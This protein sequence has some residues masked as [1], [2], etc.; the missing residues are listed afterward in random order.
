MKAGSF[1][2]EGS[3][4]FFALHAD[5]AYD[6]ICG[7]Y[8]SARWAIR[9]LSQRH[10]LTE[11]EVEEEIRSGLIELPDSSA[12][13]EYA[14]LERTNFRIASEGWES[15]TLSDG[16]RVKANAQRDVWELCFGEFAGEQF[17]TSD[18]AHRETQSAGKTM[19]SWGDWMEIIRTV[20]PDIDEDG[21]WKDDRSVRE[22]FGLRL[23]GY[24]N[25]RLKE[26]IYS[27][28]VGYFWT[29]GSPENE[30]HYL[31]LTSNQVIPARNAVQANGFS[32]RCLASGDYRR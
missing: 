23:A 7:T 21:G 20:K 24:H 30:G 4:R 11:D 3:E 28:S 19:P 18:A 1:H 5:E 8:L 17:F 2:G 14:P 9:E 29:A 10:G 22:T 31:L 6:Y 12:E 13:P 27:G 26:L 32:V 16:T 15:M 25:A